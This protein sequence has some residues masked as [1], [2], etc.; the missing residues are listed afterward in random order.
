[1]RGEH[2][3]DPLP[4]PPEVAKI[5]F[6][7]NALDELAVSA[8]GDLLAVSLAKPDALGARVY[9][10]S[11]DGKV[12]RGVK[13]LPNLAGM[14]FASDNALWAFGA[15]NAEVYRID[16][17]TGAVQTVA[18]TTETPGT[19]AYADHIPVALGG[20]GAG[21]VLVVIGSSPCVVVTVHPSAPSCTAAGT[22]S[23]HGSCSGPDACACNVGFVGTSGACACNSGFAGTD[24]AQCAASF[25]ACNTGYAGAACD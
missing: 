14:E 1:M 23:G 20:V 6:A 3:A 25:C 7:T 16:P 18:L 21:A 10:R 12:S 5:D 8:G 19:K 13:G 9:V 4:L 17:G 24:C 2:A 22:C 11:R 15:T